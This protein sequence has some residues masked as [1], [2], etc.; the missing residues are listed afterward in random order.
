MSRFPRYH[1]SKRPCAHCAV[2]KIVFTTAG[3]RATDC[4]R[5][6]AAMD[7]GF[8]TWQSS[9]NADLLKA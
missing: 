2:S 1:R 6:T 4:V 7:R 9:R 5:K 8:K 3:G